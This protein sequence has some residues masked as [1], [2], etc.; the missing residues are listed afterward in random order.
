MTADDLSLDLEIVPFSRAGSYLAFSLYGHATQ[1][2]IHQASGADVHEAVYLRSVQGM[3][4]RSSLLKIQLLADGAP[5]ACR[6]RTTPAVLRLERVDQPAHYAEFCIAEHE[7]VRVRT[8]GVS[9]R[10]SVEVG[11]SPFDIAYSP[12]GERV[13]VVAYLAGLKLALLPLDGAFTLDAPWQ[14]SRCVYI[15]IDF[16]PVAGA[17]GAEC[18]IEGYQSTRTPHA[19]TE[20]FD[21]AAARV[22]SE[23]RA[24]LDSTLPVPE[25]YAAARALAAYINWSCMVRPRGL[26]TRPAMYMSKN[27][28]YKIWNWDNCFNALALARQHPEMAWDQIQVF[29]DNQGDDG[30]L[31]DHVT[32]ATRSFR[33]YKPPVQGW[34]IRQ[35]LRLTPAIAAERAAQV[36]EPLCR[37]TEWWFSYR[38]DDS[39]GIPQYN[40][41]N[42]SGWDNGTSFAE[43]VPVET[44]DL[45]A[46]LVVQMDTLAEIAALLGKADD[47]RAW[48]RRADELTERL[49]AHSWDGTQFVSRRSETHTVPAG[50]TLI[51]YMPLL[52]GDRLPPEI[53]AALVQGV[54]R[55]VT[56]QGMA[57]ETPVSPLYESDGYWRGPIWGPSTHLIVDGLLAC[58]AHALAETIQRRF[59]DMAAVNGMAENFD[60]ITGEGL[61]DRAY[62]WTS[63]IF[64]ML[65]N[66]LERVP[67]AGRSPVE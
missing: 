24:W 26:L 61:R 25:P 3:A 16:A 13:E 48:S 44:P 17:A 21:Q 54:Q 51:N 6:V 50:D 8:Q 14:G 12:D 27:W 58:G 30:A 33:Y 46:F 49:I 11:D 66:R 32:D 7:T 2:Q 9:L 65:A 62:T 4:V 35:L 63:G 18:V 37:W 22:A 19:V 47:A 38:D 60:A 15:R 20:T 52:L 34:A 55:F 57:T 10:F 53:R 23:F 56:V 40:H 41:G 64:L 29:I 59:C 43:G 36:Y 5:V 42:E 1:Q 67:D 39:D 31:P 45:S 28:M